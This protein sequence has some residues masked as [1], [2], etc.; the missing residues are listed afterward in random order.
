MIPGTELDDRTFLEAYSKWMPLQH[1]LEDP[2]A[3]GTCCYSPGAFGD[4]PG[5]AKVPEFLD[6]GM[7]GTQV[8]AQE[9]MEKA[10]AHILSA[11]SPSEGSEGCAPATASE[12]T[13]ALATDVSAQ[14]P[15]SLLH[16]SCSL[17]FTALALPIIFLVTR[18][19]EFLQVM[20]VGGTEIAE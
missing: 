15:L 20:T 7:K 12:D 14:V 11:L 18:A 5:C 10:D 19:S 2:D 13:E 8:A 16:R 9:L 3:L 6:K 1:Q 17:C 4:C